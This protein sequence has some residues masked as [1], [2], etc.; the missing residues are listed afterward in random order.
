MLVVGTQTNDPKKLIKIDFSGLLHHTLIVGQSGGG[1]SFLV[2]R[3]VEE[4]LLRSRARV[5]IIDPNGDFRQ[6]SKPSTS[7]WTDFEENFSKINQ[8]S[9]AAALPCFDSSSAFLD[10]WERRRFAYLAPGRE[11][12][13]PKPSDVA[14]SLIVHWDSLDEEQRGF[15]LAA[16]A[17][18]NPKLFMGL[19]AVTE[20][21]RW[22]SNNRP[23]VDIGFHLRGMKD[24]CEQFYQSNIN[25]RQ[26]DYAKLLSQEDWSA[27]RATLEDL[28][29]RFSLWW[30]S[31]KKYSPPPHGI[32]DF[33]D[34]AFK[35]IKS[36][37]TF[38]DAM[39]LSLDA[40]SS[41]DTL[42][43]ADVA[44]ARCWKN[45][46]QFWREVAEGT[47]EDG[48]VPTFLVIDEAHN[49]APEHTNDPLRRRVTERLLQI[50]S[51]G[52]KYGLYLILAT[53][54][55]TKLHRELVPECENACVLRLQSKVET[56]FASNVLG[57]SPTEAA[58]V[59]GFT[60][61]Q[62]VFI[63]RWV[64]GANQ[65]NTKIA[66]ARISVGGG[67]L[68]NKW[69][70]IPEKT[71]SLQGSIKTQTDFIY[72][73]LVESD[74]AIKFPDLARLVQIEFG[75]ETCDGWFGKDTFKKFLASLQIEDLRF[76]NV[77]PGYVYIQ[78]R[79]DAPIEINE[80]IVEDYVGLISVSPE[81]SSAISY[82]KT[83]LDFPISADQNSYRAIFEAIYDEVSE[84][85]FNLTDSSKSVRDRCL[86]S[87]VPVGRTLVN[88]VLKGIHFSGHVFDAD[89]DQAPP[90][91]AEAY[92][93]SVL[94]TLEKNGAG[95][96][97]EKADILRTVLS[98]GLLT[99]NEKDPN[100]GS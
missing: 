37:P 74:S 60:L 98:G 21:A 84:A 6:I 72:Q 54:R 73:L 36:S 59:P 86:K 42:L 8:Y 31:S 46:K 97:A 71:P 82:A 50:A 100:N 32:A 43:A 65:L 62:G 29:S 15:L 81:V 58:Q 78:S 26:Y 20:N 17:Q 67:G 85:P 14:K 3:L 18:Q 56:D 55:P 45:A 64:G 90:V 87:G 22:L 57:L 99:S 12:Q 4:I 40:S 16:D 66:P 69:K 95:I 35:G 9:L 76:S 53:Q 80:A 25:L 94:F 10:G 68:N 77:P 52:R 27:V 51:E 28:L 24:V 39:V 61:G 1:K 13:P 79:H 63:G 83:Y 23:D 89:V 48:R 19:K 88:S 96:D 75:I 11:K 70:E 34:G 2:A 49:F 30:S 5:L 38:W 91:L 92:L 44:L 41:A 93:N 7:V 47:E 33:I